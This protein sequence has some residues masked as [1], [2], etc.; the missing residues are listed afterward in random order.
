MATE[1]LSMRKTR[2]IL[3]QKWELGRS[4]REIARS[5][6][7][8]AGAIGGVLARAKEAGLTT[9]PEVERLS[10]DELDRALYPQRVSNADPRPEPDCVWIHRERARPGVTLDLL[11]REYLEQHGGGYQYTTYPVHEPV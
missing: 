11:H 6:S 7:T 3:R 1:R 5:V 10:E 8:S 4:Y 9:W 2:E